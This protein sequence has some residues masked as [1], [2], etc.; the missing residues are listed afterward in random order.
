MWQFLLQFSP[1]FHLGT[2][3]IAYQRQLQSGRGRKVGRLSFATVTHTH[4]LQKWGLYS[5]L[6]LDICIKQWHFP[7]PCKFTEVRRKILSCTV[8][9]QNI[10]KVFCGEICSGPF[11]A[12][13]WLGFNPSQ[14]LN[15][16]AGF[17]VLVAVCSSSS[18]SWDH[19]ISLNIK[20]LNVQRC[21]GGR[22]SSTPPGVLQNRTLSL[23]CHTSAACVTSW[24]LAC[25][26]DLFIFLMHS[27]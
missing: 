8:M 6:N 13:T 9:K 17:Y 20:I 7:S 19:F 3:H 2:N 25:S 5:S 18:F 15:H 14:F 16:L 4:L 10:L 1:G 11:G 26:Q 23:A 12:I 22:L 21:A 27:S 24:L